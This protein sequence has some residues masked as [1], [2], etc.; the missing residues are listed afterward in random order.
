MVTDGWDI[1]CETVFT[2]K[3]VDLIDDKSTLVQVMAWCRQCWPRSLSPR[4]I[5]RP[6]W[7]KLIALNNTKLKFKL[8]LWVRFKAS[9]NSG[10][11]IISLIVK[12]LWPCDTI[13][14]HRSG[15]T[16]DQVMAYCLAIP[17]HYLK[18]CWFIIHEIHWYLTGGNFTETVLD[19][20]QYKMFENYIFENTV[21]S[22]R[23]QWVNTLG[24][25]DARK[26]QWAES[27][28]RYVMP[29]P[30]MLT[31]CQVDP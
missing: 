28:F 26:I 21:T 24:P 16:L 9:I 22:P 2:W 19:T 15:S 5:T 20:T 12:S 6:Q 13:W 11:G 31:Y 4:G 14:S 25:H 8:S 3:S 18:Q 7:V 23:C 30:E 27:H 10:N 29:Q 1:S 17:S